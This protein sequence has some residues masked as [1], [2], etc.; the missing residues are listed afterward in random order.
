MKHFLFEFISGGGLIGLTFPDSL[1]R[2]ARTMVQTLIKELIAC[3]HYKITITRES[4]V[5]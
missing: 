5:Q 2:E 3:G 4:R 1:V